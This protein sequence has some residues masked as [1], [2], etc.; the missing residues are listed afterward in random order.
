MFSIQRELLLPA[1]P[2]GC[3]QIT[4]AVVEAVPEIAQVGVG[5]LHVFIQHTSASLTLN[6]NADP[7]VLVDLDT[8]LSRLVPE[9][10]HYCH[11][12]E[13]P[14]DMP[15]HGKASL[16]GASV[17]IPVGDGRLRL[18]TWQG[19]CLCEHRDHGGRRRLVITLQGG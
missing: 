5:V 11:T 3:H 14:D 15:A 1:M 2:R 18:G 10:A 12:C 7:D 4:D 16:M 8:V 9:G 13:G 17:S 19:L 6:E